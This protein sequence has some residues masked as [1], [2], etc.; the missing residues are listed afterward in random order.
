MP[1]LE[2]IDYSILERFS[3]VAHAISAKPLSNF[4]E[5]EVLVAIADRCDFKFSTKAEKVLTSSQTIYFTNL[6][7]ARDR[8][9]RQSSEIIDFYCDHEEADTKIFA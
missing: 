3:N 1:I 7:G 8:V 4:L 9:T 2:S 5:C 6:D